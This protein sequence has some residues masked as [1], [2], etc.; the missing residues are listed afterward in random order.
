MLRF[1]GV[2]DLHY[3]EG[4]SERSWA[5]IFVANIP[6][7]LFKNGH[8]ALA[9]DSILPLAIDPPCQWRNDVAKTSLCECSPHLKNV[10]R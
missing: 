4:L 9:L 3:H 2:Y 7:A 6:V 10:R 8:I 5:I 1:P